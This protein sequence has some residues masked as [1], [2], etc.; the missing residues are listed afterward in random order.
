MKIISCFSRWLAGALLALSTPVLAAQWDADVRNCRLTKIGTDQWQAVFTYYITSCPGCSATTLYNTFRASVPL[1]DA[2]GKPQIDTIANANLRNLI[3]TPASVLKITLNPATEFIARNGISTSANVIKATSTVSVDFST[4]GNNAYPVLVVTYSNVTDK[5]NHTVYSYRAWVTS[6]TCINT[7]AGTTL[8]PSELPPID[9]VNPPEPVF[10]L[11]SAVWDLGTVDVGSIPDVTAAGSGYTA[12]ISN[13]GNNNLC[14]SYATA[15]VKKNTYALGVTNS[16][17]TQAGRN[18][19]TMQG[20]NNSS[21]FYNLQLVSNDGVTGNNFDFPA[22]VTKYITLSQAASGVD[23]RSEMC[24]MPKINLFRNTS[25]TAGIHNDTV[26]FI[27][28]PKA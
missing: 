21:L 20:A 16:V 4:A 9:E 18:L 22:G 28:T 13:I 24:W 15:G 14:V 8:P 6:N 25:T 12:S 10:T 23:K 11:K 17:S 19:F 2:N 1:V 26:N 7:G 3:V 5:N 27:I